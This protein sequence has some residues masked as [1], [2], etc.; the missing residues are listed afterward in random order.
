MDRGILEYFG[1][2]GIYNKINKLSNIF[3]KMHNE[4]IMHLLLIMLTGIT[5]GLIISLLDIKLTTMV[6]ILLLIL[7]QE[8]HFIK[9]KVG[10]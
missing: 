7:Y 5:M 8:K 1:A 10:I 2:F 9:I 4:N 6:I 3:Q